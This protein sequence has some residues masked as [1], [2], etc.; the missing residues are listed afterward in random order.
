MAEAGLRSADV[1]RA[2]DE[3]GAGMSRSAQHV[4]LTVFDLTLGI[5][6]SMRRA[7]SIR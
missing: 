2:G 1:A 3:K 7:R 4:E 5:D 6:S